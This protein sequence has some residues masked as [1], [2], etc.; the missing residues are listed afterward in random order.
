MTTSGNFSCHVCFSK[1]LKVARFKMENGNKVLIPESNPLPAYYDV[2]GFPES[3][4]TIH[5]HHLYLDLLVAFRT[6]FFDTARRLKK[7]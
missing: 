6:R 3:A 5:D 7:S 2:S 1:K 4:K